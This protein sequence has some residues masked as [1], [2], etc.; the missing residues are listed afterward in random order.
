M[1]PTR[2][3]RRTV[4]VRYMLAPEVRGLST[5]GS[6][7]VVEPSGEPAL[8]AIIYGL[9]ENYSKKKKQVE[10]QARFFKYDFIAFPRARFIFPP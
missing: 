9:S 4:R 6:S 5:T 7:F 10:K 2:G 8:S 3:H 1:P